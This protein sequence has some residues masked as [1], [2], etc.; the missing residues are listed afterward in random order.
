MFSILLT[1]VLVSIF[2]F[3]VYGRLTYLCFILRF[4]SW[5]PLTLV[6]VKTLLLAQINKQ[7]N[8]HS[9]TQNAQV[10]EIRSHHKLHPLPAC[11]L[12]LWTLIFCFLV[13]FKFSVCWTRDLNKLE[14]PGFSYPPLIRLDV[15]MED[16]LGASHLVTTFLC[17]DEAI[18]LVHDVMMVP[19]HIPI[20]SLKTCCPQNILI[21]L[22]RFLNAAS[23]PHKCIERFE[24]HILSFE[25][26]T[27][28]KKHWSVFSIFFFTRGY[29]YQAVSFRSHL[30][31][32]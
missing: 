31:M 19:C 20:T 10:K 23:L 18:Q 3:S 1:L 25:S 32:K 17:T 24:N 5:L 13:Y 29:S 4:F 12:R 9:H 11:L 16:N 22:F 27:Y 15:K 14:Y 30:G 26:L 28:P 8:I 6:L 7:T 2:T 21:S